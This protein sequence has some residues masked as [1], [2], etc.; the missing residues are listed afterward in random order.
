MVADLSYPRLLRSTVV[1]DFALLNATTAQAAL[2]EEAE[3]SAPRDH[4][5][6]APLVPSRDAARVVD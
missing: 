6:D 2:T 5:T 4:V 3:R 1:S